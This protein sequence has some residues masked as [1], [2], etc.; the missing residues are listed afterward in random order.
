MTINSFTTSPSLGHP[1][2]KT[3]AAVLLLASCN[4]CA[5]QDEKAPPPPPMPPPHPLFE[6]ID[7]DHDGKLSAEEIAKASQSIA[8]LDHNGDGQIDRAEVRPPHPPREHSG[9][10]PPREGDAASPP[11]PPNPY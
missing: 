3:A 8:A 7:L 6:A 4:L 10:A 11:P 2:R 9:D 5:A 1:F